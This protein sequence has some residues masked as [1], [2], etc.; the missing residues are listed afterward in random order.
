MK[1]TDP[2]RAFGAIIGKTLKPWDEGR[3]TADDRRPACG[4]F[5]PPRWWCR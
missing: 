3:E 1:A 2:T 4:A 5:S